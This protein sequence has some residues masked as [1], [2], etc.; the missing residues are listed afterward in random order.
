MR[1][2]TSQYQLKVDSTTTPSTSFLK[3]SRPARI[4]GS[5]FLNRCLWSTWF[6]S[7]TMPTYVFVACKSIP[8]YTF[9][10]HLLDRFGTSFT[11]AQ[12]PVVYGEVP[13]NDYQV[14]PSMT[15]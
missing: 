7:S 4:N 11:I 15:A 5:S 3:G 13:S 9:T 10:G 12:L 6:S 14:K 8:T 2:S 1:P